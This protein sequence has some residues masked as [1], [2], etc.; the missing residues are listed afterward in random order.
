MIEHIVYIKTL[1]STV[2]LHRQTHS[3]TMSFTALYWLTKKNTRGASSISN[4][5]SLTT[6]QHTSP[7]K[8]L[9][10]KPDPADP[11][12]ETMN[13]VESNFIFSMNISLTWNIVQFAKEITKKICPAIVWA[14]SLKSYILYMTYTRPLTPSRHKALSLSKTYCSLHSYVFSRL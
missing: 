6:T 1:C 13:P 7:R 12:I 14:N 10:K 8:S 3:Y 4:S 9:Q 11:N 5:V 2:Y